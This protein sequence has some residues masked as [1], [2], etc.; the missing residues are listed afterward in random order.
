MNIIGNSIKLEDLDKFQLQN[1]NREIVSDM[2]LINLNLKR[3]NS[4]IDEIKEKQEIIKKLMNGNI[5]TENAIIPLTQTLYMKG[6]IE[7]NKRIIISIGDK[8]YVSKTYEKALI[9]YDERM[10][11]KTKEKRTFEILLNDRTNVLKKMEVIVKK[12]I[13]L[14][15]I[16]KSK[17]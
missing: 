6:T 14:E 13:T 17:L 2:E 5:Q 8:F 1:L 16:V 9:Y 4:E 11:E 3:I 15:Q 12:L 7:L 10:K